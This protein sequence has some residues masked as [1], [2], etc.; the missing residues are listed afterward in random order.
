MT[1]TIA[2]LTGGQRYTK[3]RF[4]PAAAAI[5]YL[6]PRFGKQDDWSIDMSEKLL[7]VDEL[8]EIW[9]PHYSTRAIRRLVDLNQLPAVRI[10]V[11]LFFRESSIR[12]FLANA[13]NEAELAL[14]SGE[15]SELAG[16]K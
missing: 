12:K 1:F 10:G 6:F 15:H 5:G 9:L 7:T 11:R 14:H 8:R 16:S 2:A 4:A 13:G 3:R